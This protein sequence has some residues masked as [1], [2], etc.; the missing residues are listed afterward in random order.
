MKSVVAMSYANTLNECI[1]S[2]TNTLGCVD[3]SFVN[4]SPG[5]CYMKSKAGDIVPNSNIWGGRQVS[6]CTT[7]THKLKLKLHRKRVVRK[8]HKSANRIQQRA[9]PYGPDFTYYPGQA[10]TTTTTSTVT[11]TAAPT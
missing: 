9:I 5:P 8:D 1:E 4:G 10:Q 7:A 3:V 2:C 6:G 11:Q